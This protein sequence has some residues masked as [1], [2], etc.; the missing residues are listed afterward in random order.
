MFIVWGKKVVYRKL[1]HV[2]DFCPICREV[3]AF[4]VRRVGVAGHVYYISFGDGELAGHDRTCRSCG[5]IL[6]ADLGSYASLSPTDA[7][8]LE[9][10]IGQTFP[11]LR[12]AAGDRLAIEEQVQQSPD[13][14][15]PDER[16]ALL[17]EPFLLLSPKV[18]Q[19]FAAVHIDKEIGLALAAVLGLCILGPLLAAQ[20][21]SGAG[22]DAFLIALALGAVLVVW[23]GVG[24]GRRYL[25]RQVIPALATA[26]RP[27]RP[28]EQELQQVLGELKSHKLKIGRKL[29]LADL[30]AQL[31]APPR[32]AAEARPNR[33][34]R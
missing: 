3:R 28:Q 22:F 27:L 2:A 11:N 6:K 17:R 32:P 14:F 24:A 29:R 13:S 34:V 20:L 9:A 18:D 25:A 12:E 10:L 16:R 7:G 4:E 5:I 1:G 15:S 23:M 8:P 33:L 30:Q 21:R 31:K 19:R 26:L